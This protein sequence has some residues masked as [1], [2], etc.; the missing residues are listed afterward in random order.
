[1]IPVID[2]ST[3]IQHGFQISKNL[4]LDHLSNGA[5][6]TGLGEFLPRFSARLIPSQYNTI[7]TPGGIPLW[8][9]A[10]SLQLGANHIL[11]NMISGFGS[12]L[13]IR[14]GFLNNVSNDLIKLGINELNHRLGSGL[15]IAIRGYEDN[16]YPVVKEIAKIANAANRM[17]I[18]YNNSS[19]IHLDF[20]PKNLSF[21]D[22][23][24]EGP[25]ISTIDEI[26]G[27]VEKGITTIRGFI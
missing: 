5:Y 27:I 16:V 12:D 1:M 20:N 4:L 18:I 6:H 13:I 10:R 21:N 8:Y 9:V 7:F 23:F 19:Y 22:R 25:I 14:S 3:V 2:S 17:S 26:T 15:D 24:H 11:E